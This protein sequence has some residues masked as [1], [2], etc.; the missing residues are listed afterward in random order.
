M[1]SSPANSYVRTELIFNISEYASASII[2][3][4]EIRELTVGI[5]TTGSCVTNQGSRSPGRVLN[6][7][8]P[9]Y[10]AGHVVQ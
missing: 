7:A 4:D 1:K 3:V 10:E 2:R 6:S 9:E 5:Q 8:P